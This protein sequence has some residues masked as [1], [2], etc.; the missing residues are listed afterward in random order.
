MDVMFGQERSRLL[1]RPAGFV[2]CRLVSTMELLLVRIL[3]MMMKYD[4]YC[5]NFNFVYEDWI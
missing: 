5:E 1:F 3:G 2:Q 4:A